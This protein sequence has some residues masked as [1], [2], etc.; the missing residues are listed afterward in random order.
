MPRITTKLTTAVE[1]YFSDLRRIRASGGATGE[2]SYY[3]A[4]TNPLNA[5]GGALKPK[6]FSVSELAGQGACHP[7]LGLYALIGA[8]IKQAD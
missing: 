4:L 2:R 3:P 8:Q 7:D 1:D 5:V 6:V